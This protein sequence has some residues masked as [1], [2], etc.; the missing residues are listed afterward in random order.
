MG[1]IFFLLR[2]GNPSVDPYGSASRWLIFGHREFWRSCLPATWHGEPSH[3]ATM[4]AFLHH[5]PDQK[6]SGGVWYIDIYWLYGIFHPIFPMKTI[7]PSCFSDTPPTG[8]VFCCCFGHVSLGRWE[9]LGWDLRAQFSVSGQTLKWTQDLLY[10]YEN[11]YTHLYIYIIIYHI[12]S[13]Y[14]VFFVTTRRTAF[15]VDLRHSKPFFTEHLPFISTEARRACWLRKFHCTPLRT[16]SRRGMVGM[17]GCRSCLPTW[18]WI[19]IS[20]WWKD[21]TFLPGIAPGIGLFWVVDVAVKWLTLRVMIFPIIS[22]QWSSGTH[23][24][25]DLCGYGFHMV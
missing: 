1:T 5:F 8:L 14:I 11:Q 13:T 12:I 10:V 15:L 19:G 3:G 2:T 18:Q 17:V 23:V 7:F 22:V 16:K 9:D 21:D 20:P 4:I 6:P 25:Q 24:N